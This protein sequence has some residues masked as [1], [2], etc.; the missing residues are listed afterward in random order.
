[1]GSHILNMNGLLQYGGNK[2]YT[3]LWKGLVMA[4]WD[5]KCSTKFINKYQGRQQ[6]ISWAKVAPGGVESHCLFESQ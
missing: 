3:K 5:S 1:M 6:D 4:S 2:W